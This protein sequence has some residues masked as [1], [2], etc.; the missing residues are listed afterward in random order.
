MNLKREIAETGLG[1]VRYWGFVGALVAAL[2]VGSFLIFNMH[3]NA[4]ECARQD[5]QKCQTD[6]VAISRESA[7]ANFE[8][9]KAILELK[10]TLDRLSRAI[11]TKYPV[12]VQ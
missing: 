4:T 12:I 6:L 11:E 8:M 7:Q 1:V 5:L 3:L 2:L 10:L 9:S